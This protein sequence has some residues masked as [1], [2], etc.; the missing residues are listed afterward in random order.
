MNYDPFILPFSIGASI[1]ILTLILKYGYWIYKLDKDEK[2]K[3]VRGFFSIKLFKGIRE[4]FLESLIHRKIF[5]ENALLGYMHMSLAFGWFL[6][7]IGG[8]LES[9]IHSHRPFNM[10]YEPIFFKFFNHNINIYPWADEFKFIMDFLLLLVLSGVVL[11]LIKRVWSRLFGMKKTT[12]LRIGDRF[13]LISLWLIFP[14]RFFAESITSGLYN[15]GGFL[16]G[17][18]GKVFAYTL[19]LETLY[20]PTWWAYSS[21]L[22]VFFL[23][24]PYSRYMHIFTE[25]VLIF[26]RN[27]GIKSCKV[28]NAYS[29]VEV[30]SCSR[31]GLCI[32][33]CPLLTSSRIKDTQAVYFLQSVRNK[34]VKEEKAFD[35]LLCGRCQEF[36]P[37]GIGLN[38]I[39]VSQRLDFAPGLQNFNFIN[40]QQK[41]KATV[42]YFA[43]CMTH[44]TPTI[45][46]AMEEIFKKAG[47]DYTFIDKDGGI[48]CGRPLMVSGEIM[49]AHKLIE[50]NHN[51][52]KE[53]GAKTLVT[54]CPICLK[55]F[56]E[57]YK[58]N[59]EIIHHSQFL[60]R[61]VN[62]R[63][64][65]LNK[66]EIKAVY[67]DPCELGR[68]CGVYEE[69]RQLLQ[70]TLS[71]QRIKNEK[72]SSMCCGNSIGGLH[73]NHVQREAITM[74]ATAALLKYKPELI[75]TSCPLCKKTFAK[76]PETGVKDIAEVVVASMRN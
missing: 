73:V 19:P 20:Y 53:S 68:G 10:P 58:L 61:L 21:V 29:K 59:I 11:A 12:K 42:A 72:E 39:R 8:S 4:V 9:K 43:G 28:F 36:C 32:D 55:S 6:L 27:F 14:L 1:L 52:I 25:A 7:I 26:L 18:A 76:N 38:N 49:K 71:L 5:K 45:K 48:C 17:N 64:I 57:D 24:L 66:S 22:C 37:V 30:Y 41:E 56:K 60:L 70:K 23:A 65:S 16:T 62:E 46:I 75:V 2:I 31:C 44:L 3:I 63:K 69:P 50:K 34:N 15:N 47:T 54:S 67:H 51:L 35:C 33:K 74:D 40:P 13:A